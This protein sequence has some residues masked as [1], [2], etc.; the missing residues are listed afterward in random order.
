MGPQAFLDTQSAPRDYRIEVTGAGVVSVFVD[1]VLTLS[2]TVL[3]SPAFEDSKYLWWGDGTS[4]ASGTSFW[5][6]FTHNGDAR[7]S[8]LPTA[9]EHSTW[10]RIKG[11]Y[12]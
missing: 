8:C 5:E 4:H 12:R 3:S 1:G 7:E 2:G 10:G 6:T 9:V 11:L